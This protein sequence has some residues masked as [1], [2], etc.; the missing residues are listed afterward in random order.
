MSANRFRPVPIEDLD[1]L[2]LIDAEM[3]RVF[4]KTPPSNH[5]R[6]INKEAGSMRGG[7]KT[8]CVIK[9]NG[10]PYKR[11][12]IVFAASRRIWPSDLIDHING[13]ST[14]DR[15][16]NLREANVFQNAWNHKGRRKSSPL[17]MGVRFIGGRY[18]ARISHNKKMIY[19]GVFDSADSASAVYQAKR[20]ELFGEYA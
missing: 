11:S 5:T 19:L 16:C 13:I 14:D 1:R 20:K 12:Y 17:P 10:I 9:I 3:G 6:L 15:L 8:Y 2:F 7:R 4:W 18:Q